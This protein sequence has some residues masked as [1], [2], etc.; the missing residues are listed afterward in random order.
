MKKARI[1]CP[2]VLL[3]STCLAASPARLPADAA[4][5]STLRKS[6]ERLVRFVLDNGMTG[7]VKE[8]HSAP[9][10]SIQIWVGIGSIHEGELLGGGM[11]HYV[12]HMI[13][14]GTPTR[15]PGDIARIVQDAGGQINAYTSLDRTVFHTD[16]PSARWR[17]GL[18]A[19]GDAVMHATFPEEEC[20]KEKNVIL[21]EMSMKQDS[22][23]AL[24]GELLWRTAY[25]AHPYRLPV[26]GLKQIFESVTRD[27]LVSYFHRHYV[28]DNMVVAV[29]G[30]ISAAEAEKTLRDTFAAFPRRP[31]PP[32]LLPEEPRQQSPRFVRETKPMQVSRLH[33]A[34]H[35][36]S[37]S[38]RDAPTLDVLA[39]IVGS[40]RSSR[41]VQRI[42]EEQ[43][44]VHSI[45][46][47]SFTPRYPGLFVVSAQCDPDKEAAAIAAINAEI[48]SWAKTS[49][50]ESEVEKARRM[51]LVGEL[52]SLQTMHGQ[53][54][55]Y[56]SGMMFQH[57]PLYAEA[58][59]DLLQKVNPAD[60]SAAALTYL[61]PPNR[62]TVVLGPA[63]KE[64]SKT[65]PAEASQAV[66][67]K[68]DI[69][70]NEIP[71]ILRE[72]H[73]IPF[74]SV[75][76]AFRGGVISETQTNAGITRLM[77]DLL[78][79]G[80]SKRSAAEIA[81]A[82]ESLGA[83]LTSFSGYNSLGLQFRCLAGDVETLMD[84][85]FDCLAQPAFSPE[86]V[87]KQKTVQLAA[88][89]AQREKPFFIAQEALESVIFA[90]HPYRWNPLGCRDSVKTLDHDALAAYGRNIL[91]SGNMSLAIF[92]DITP[93]RAK[94]LVE[95]HLR[96]IRSG[97]APVFGAA[98]PKPELPARLQR[99][100]PREQCIV[101]F[102]FPGVGMTDP[103]RDALD[104]LDTAMSGM[105]SRMFKTIRDERGLAYYA[106]ASQRCG[107]GTGI[108]SLYTGTRSDALDEVERLIREEIARVGQTGLTTEEIA[109]AK[110]Q[111]IADQ[112]M[113]LQD[114]SA[115]A[116]TSALN[117]LYGL[118]YDY[119][120]KIRQR[121]E[122]ITP[123]QVRESAASVL[124]T[125]RMAI[126]IVL[127]SGTK[128][129]P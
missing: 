47:S 124:S 43:K 39:A 44:L 104:V 84:I 76:A 19:L 10:V 100:E 34:F 108:F 125:N 129:L 29:V 118:G 92:G 99:Q 79:K 41:L 53:A 75:C 35:T 91:I 106:G 40:G 8:D 22:P 90:G 16:L 120:F 64:A 1:L 67:M 74:V 77:S 119:D 111:I 128:E 18:D 114:N 69:M 117:E 42:K 65:A 112:E 13:F 95:K 109:R 93:E 6:N 20:A 72:D 28:P 107:V 37:V 115:L 94:S 102:G 2:I 110:N 98:Q 48:A 116:M 113:R 46:A 122:A 9:V 70:A 60:L 4:A 63:V 87:G 36:V 38:D 24:A 101:L 81:E 25:V 85:L 103:R 31:N 49:F 78:V 66:A 51:V 71:L 59:L 105:S 32:T 68:R 15:K 83:E 26:I 57:D 11:S 96:R 88:I 33:M 56:A 3:A 127:P 54:D 12:E 82:T 62:T 58:Y 30:D 73:R 14:K 52:E 126:S 123:A 121:I 23:D 7:L 17:V 80:T 86:E 50:P 97:A 21:R 45:G 55:S 5:L 27:N 61:R 89:D